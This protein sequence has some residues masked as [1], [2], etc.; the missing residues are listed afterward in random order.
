MDRNP[1]P[2]QLK[3]W[4]E[5]YLAG[6]ISEADKLLLEAWYTEIPDAPVEWSDPAV[7]AASDLQMKLLKGIDKDIYRQERQQRHRRRRRAVQVSA[8]VLILGAGLAFLLQNKNK[9]ATVARSYPRKTEIQPGSI[10]ATLQLADGKTIKLDSSHSV[11]VTSQQGHLALLNTQGNAT[12]VS[13][14]PERSALN[15]L[16]TRRGEQAPPIT[17]PDGTK[18]WVNAASTLHFPTSFGNGAREVAL[19]GEAYFE[20][21]KDPRHP[22]I[23]STAANKVEV[24]GTHF[25]VMAYADEQLSRTTLLE[26]SIRLRNAR[27]SVQLKPGQQ[28]STDAGNEIKVSEVDATESVAWMNGQLSMR[29]M[30]IPAFMRSVSRWYD[31]DVQYAGSL[32]ALSFSATLNKSIPLSQ[33]LA[34]LNENGVHCRLQGRTVIVSNQ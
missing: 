1:S 12:Y 9:Q 17:L 5:S 18:V 32:P 4:I 22:F 3:T 13:N 27:N 14:L 23:V 31:V 25:D 29:Y 34:A 6:T 24:L 8:L 7:T 30:D 20:V 2:E 33:L 11:N 19:S 16:I 21:A 15:T 28:A 26:G 10:S